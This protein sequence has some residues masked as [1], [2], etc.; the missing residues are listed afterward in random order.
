MH[1]LEPQTI[2][3][4]NLLKQKRTPFVVALNKIDR[5]YDWKPDPN[6][7][8]QLTLAAQKQQT[9]LEFEK[10]AETVV[11]LLAAQ[12][13]NCCLYYKNPDPRKYVSLV[14]TSA[15]TG[16]GQLDANATSISYCTVCVCVFVC[17]YT[18]I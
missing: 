5:C 7:P 2:E 14:P 3:S 16:E 8:F 12:S 10:R 6:A 13:L 9:Q 4:I 1:G 17:C 15:I 18:M 11:G